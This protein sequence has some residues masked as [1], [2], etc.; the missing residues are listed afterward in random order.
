MGRGLEPGP[1]LANPGLLA[2]CGTRPKQNLGYER[3]SM[4]R[5]HACGRRDIVVPLITDG[6][7]VMEVLNREPFAIVED[8]IMAIGLRKDFAE[9]AFAVTG[10][11]ELHA[12]K[13]PPTEV[14]DLRFP[15][16]ARILVFEDRR[17]V[18]REV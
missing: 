3:V 8:V 5:E 10:L 4:F 11:Q 15:V 14:P 13:I 16:P 6:R 2:A 17:Q 7:I 12:I 9:K 1:F 18:F